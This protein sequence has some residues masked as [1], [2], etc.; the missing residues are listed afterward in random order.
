MEETKIDINILIGLYDQRILE[1]ESKNILLQTEAQQLKI[2][3]SE[4]EGKLCEDKKEFEPKEV[5]KN[6][7]CKES[8]K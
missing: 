6:V 1:L 4:L 8:V 7:P 2:V 5:T 3:I